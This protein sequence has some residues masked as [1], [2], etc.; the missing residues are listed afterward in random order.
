MLIYTKKSLFQCRPKK[1]GPD[2]GIP[3]N[4]LEALLMAYYCHVCIKQINEENRENTCPMLE[5]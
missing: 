5:K 1:I 4:D 3:D 2:G